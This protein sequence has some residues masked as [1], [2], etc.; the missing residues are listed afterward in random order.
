MVKEKDK[1]ARD[2]Y[3]RSYD[4]RNNTDPKLKPDDIDSVKLDKDRGWTTPATVIQHSG[5]PRSYLI[6]TEKGVLRRNRRHPRLLKQPIVFTA[7][8]EEEVAETGHTDGDGQ[9]VVKTNSPET[10]RSLV[11]TTSR[12]RVIRPNTRYKN[13]VYYVE[14]SKRQN[15]PQHSY[16]R[17]SG[18]PPSSL[19]L[20]VQFVQ[21]N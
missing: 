2:S 6:R 17:Q 4:R 1:R 3:K 12:G 7:D 9:E 8:E 21:R 15:N 19:E 5:M 14:C 10:P 18:S 16:V 20:T 11:Q 13:F